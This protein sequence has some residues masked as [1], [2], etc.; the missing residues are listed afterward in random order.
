MKAITWYTKADLE[1][2]G[3]IELAAWISITTIGCLFF[4]VALGTIRGM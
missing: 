2:M 3:R 4:A 1:N